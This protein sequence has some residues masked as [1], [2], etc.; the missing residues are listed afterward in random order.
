MPNPV[1][2]ILIVH[3]EQERVEACIRDVHPWVEQIVAVDQEST[4]WTRDILAR[5]HQ[6]RIV[7]VYVQHPAYGTAEASRPEAFE[8]ATSN[9]LL[10]LDADEVLTA[11][12]KERLPELLAAEIDFYHLRRVTRIEGQLIEDCP[13]RRL[14]RRGFASAPRFENIGHYAH[15]SIEI[16]PGAREATSEFVAITSD[17]TWAE[18]IIDNERSDVLLGLRPA[19]DPDH[20]KE[21][22][23]QPPADA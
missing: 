5:L 23:P 15:S 18:Q 7:D 21:V 19:D 3:N 14:F 20:G 2:V 12:F 10:I 9:W 22:G 13:H 1:S 11:E 17:K 4:D 6:H 16:A 8:Y